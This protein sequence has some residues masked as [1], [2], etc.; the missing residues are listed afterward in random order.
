MLEHDFENA[1][2]TC[3]EAGNMDVYLLLHYFQ[4]KHCISGYTA[5]GN[6][7]IAVAA[8]M[9]ASIQNSDAV[10]GNEFEVLN[11]AHYSECRAFAEGCLRY[12][13]TPF[14]GIVRRTKLYSFIWIKYPNLPLEDKND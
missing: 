14:S 3:A 8:L 9:Y 13:V 7:I 2:F 10:F 4:K 6:F 11:I 5:V 1:L 12:L